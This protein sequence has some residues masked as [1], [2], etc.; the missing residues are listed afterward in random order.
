MPGTQKTKRQAESK[1]VQETFPAL[2]VSRFTAEAD[3][4]LL[5][6]N[7]WRLMKF[8]QIRTIIL[9]PIHDIKLLQNCKSRAAWWGKVVIDL[10]CRVQKGHPIEQLCISGNWAAELID[11]DTED[12]GESMGLVDSAAIMCIRA[13]VGEVIDERQ[14]YVYRRV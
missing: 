11:V 8:P 9:D 3:Q 13:F 5:F 7:D 14:Q 1:H 4:S 10:G 2:T 6:R 12:T